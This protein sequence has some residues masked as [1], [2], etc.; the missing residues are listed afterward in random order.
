MSHI[1]WSSKTQTQPICGA[2]WEL[3]TTKLGFIIIHKSHHMATLFFFLS[4]ILFHHFLVVKSGW[5]TGK[6]S[7][8]Q[9][10]VP[11]MYIF[12]DC[13]VDSGINPDLHFISST[14]NYYPY[15][16]DFPIGSTGR[17]SNGGTIADFLGNILA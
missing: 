6:S 14:V 3:I 1:T 16:I 5:L 8:T 7:S 13:Q 15:G 12:G 11:A 4:L 9:P 2:S 10:L 17:F